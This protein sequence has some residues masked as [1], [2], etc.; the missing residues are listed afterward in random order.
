[1]ATLLFE[2]WFGADES[3]DRGEA[4]A[5]S[6][7]PDMAG[8]ATLPADDRIIVERVNAGDSSAL[9]ELHGIYWEPLVRSATRMLGSGTIDVATDV[10]QDVFVDLWT[11]RVAWAPQ[12]S[13]A[14]HLFRAVRNR[15][16]Q[17]RRNT[18]TAARWNSATPP[19]HWMPVRSVATPS[20]ELLAHELNA[21][22]HATLLSLAPRC[23][24]AFLL[25]AEQK[26]E[27]PEIASVMGIAEGT[28]Q[29]QLKRAM[30][31][32]RKALDAY[33]RDEDDR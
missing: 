20:E 14:T 6:H 3:S 17:I 28:A 9:A 16:L 26:L 22:A 32:L 10:V 24:E 18:A 21:L 33:I 5:R 12:R 29:L 11:R 2:F 31:A 15:A 4:V 7:R 8:E 13:I 23:R 19:R 25:Y 1:M 30:A 27:V